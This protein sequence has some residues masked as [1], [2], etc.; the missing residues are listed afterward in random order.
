MPSPDVDSSV[1]RLDVS[2]VPTVEVSSPEMFFK[3]VKGGF[4]QRRKTLVN[5]LSSFFG[6]PKGNIVSI[7]EELQIQT[8]IGPEQLTIEQFAIISDKLS[9]MENKL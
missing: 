2:P 1:I 9:E 3:T 4:S 8:T 7:L 5:S 6:M